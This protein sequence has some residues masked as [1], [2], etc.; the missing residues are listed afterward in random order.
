MGFIQSSP[1]NRPSIGIRLGL[2]LFG[3]VIS[4]ESAA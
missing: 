4:V 1:G 2:W 3:D